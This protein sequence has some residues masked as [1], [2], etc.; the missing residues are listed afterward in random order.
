MAMIKIFKTP[1]PAQGDKI[2]ISLAL[3]QQ[4]KNITLVEDRCLWR[5][6]LDPRPLIKCVLLVECTAPPTCN[7]VVFT[8]VSEYNY[9]SYSSNKVRKAQNKHL[10]IVCQN[11]TDP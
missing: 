8:Y 3:S 4:K 7:L 1:Q 11:L 5:I 2:F 9:M 6:P 10:N